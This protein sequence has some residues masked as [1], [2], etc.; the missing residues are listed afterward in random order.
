MRLQTSA[1]GVSRNR[2][3]CFDDGHPEMHLG[4]TSS[5]VYNFGSAHSI[6]QLQSK[7]SVIRRGFAGVVCAPNVGLGVGSVGIERNETPCGTLKR[8]N[9]KEG[10]ASVLVVKKMQIRATT[11]T[12]DN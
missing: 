1:V 3:S 11:R 10:L 8:G 6:R 4:K 5:Y 9:R 2:D 7:H 12:T